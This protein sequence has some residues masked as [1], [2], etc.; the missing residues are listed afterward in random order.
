MRH[1]STGII[2]AGGK[3]TRMGVD[4]A[5]L[6]IRGRTLIEEVLSTFKDVFSE[7]IIVADE[8]EKFAFLGERTIPDRV[9][10]M[11]PL[12][13]LITGLM[14]SGTFHNFVTA[15][16]MPFLHREMI[17]YMLERGLG[18]DAVVPEYKG[19]L[20]PLCA[21]YSKNCIRPIQGQLC[22]NNLKITDIFAHVRTRLITG[23]EIERWDPAG[24]CFMN[25]NT[26]EDY[27][28]CQSAARSFD[29]CQA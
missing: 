6:K 17:E 5:F 22:Q 13:G 16:D 19:R 12:G 27:E 14:T 4:K 21:V 7:T 26:A 28:R 23:R 20:E 3:S 1:D 25:M 11:G 18:Y 8:I 2:L 24:T 15:C 29:P 10:F 9:P